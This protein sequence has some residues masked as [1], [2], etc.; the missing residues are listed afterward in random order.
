M[1]LDKKSSEEQ[2]THNLSLS[3]IKE[4]ENLTGQISVLNLASVKIAVIQHG[5]DNVRKAVNK[6]LEKGKFK[7]V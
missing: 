1:S 4:F 5:Y 3:L 6:A 2:D 7:M